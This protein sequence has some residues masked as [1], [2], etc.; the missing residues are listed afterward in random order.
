MPSVPAWR[1][2]VEF[3]DDDKEESVARDCVRPIVD[4]K[5]EEEEGDYDSDENSDY[6]EEE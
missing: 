1:V 4:E 2:D 3:D 6:S 5:E